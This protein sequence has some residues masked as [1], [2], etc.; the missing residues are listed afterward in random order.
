MHTPPS[1]WKKWQEVP[2]PCQESLWNFID[3]PEDEKFIKILVKKKP[4]LRFY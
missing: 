3:F 1:A 2:Q 4:Y